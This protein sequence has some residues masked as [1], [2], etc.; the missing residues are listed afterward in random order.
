MNAFHLVSRNPWPW[1]IIAWFLVF[2]SALGAWVAVALRQNMDLVRADYYEA[3]IR[4]QQQVER[5][6][7][8]ARAGQ[9]MHI[10][11]DAARREVALCLPAAHRANQPDGRIHFYRPSNAALD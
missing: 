11:Y 8:T 5:L 7:R 2:G 9:E 1:A 4:Y 10:A 3:E 6:Q